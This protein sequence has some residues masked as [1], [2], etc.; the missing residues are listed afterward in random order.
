MQRLVAL[1]TG[2]TEISQL[3]ARWL[4]EDA[5]MLKE[6]RAHCLAQHILANPVADPSTH[7][8]AEMSRIRRQCEHVSDDDG[9]YHVEVFPYEH[10]SPE[11]ILRL[12]QHPQP[13]EAQA[14]EA[15]NSDA[16]KAPMASV[17]SALVSSARQT[18]SG[19]HGRD[20]RRA[21]QR[22]TTRSGWPA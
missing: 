20:G 22:Q 13:F 21:G 5:P 2:E 15:Q 7:I 10:Y 1:A 16:M 17:Q 3:L 8:L 6:Q 9:P 19:C 12:G 14:L 11:D 4:K 18:V